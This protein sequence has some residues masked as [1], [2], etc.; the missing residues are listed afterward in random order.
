M[1]CSQSG[2]SVSK[3]IEQLPGADQWVIFNPQLATLYKVNYDANNWK[4][5]IETLTKGDFERIHVLNRAQL[6]D[7]ILYFAWTGSQDYEVAL[8]LIGYLQREREFLPW[9]AAFDNLKLV[10]R[11]VRQTPH[12]DLFK[13]LVHKSYSL[14]FIFSFI[15]RSELHEQVDHA[16]L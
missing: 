12:F 2:E 15:I 3:T 6:V 9:K 1:E 13:V 16:H 7:D 10:G 5:L 8:S 4:L 11:I 14:Q